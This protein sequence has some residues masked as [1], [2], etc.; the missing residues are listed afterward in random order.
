MSKP[1]VDEIEISLFGGQKQGESIV[2][3]LGNDNWAIIDSFNG[4]KSQTPI[5][6]DYLESIQVTPDQVKVII[7][8]H[9]HNDHVKGIVDIAMSCKNAEVWIPCV[10]DGASF[11]VLMKKLNRIKNTRF[12]PLLELNALLDADDDGLIE[13][14]RGKQDMV[15]YKDVVDNKQV[16]LVC[17]SPNDKTTRHFEKHIQ[18]V[19]DDKEESSMMVKSKDPNYQSLSV[20]LKIDG[21][22]VLLTGDLENLNQNIGLES[23][24]NSKLL[25]NNT[26]TVFKVPHHGS[27]NGYNEKVWKVFIDNE[28]TYLIM[29]PI[30]VG[31][32]ILP[33]NEMIKFFKKNY[34]KL[35]ITSDPYDGSGGL[36]HKPNTRRIIS[37]LNL[38]IEK[39]QD[40]FG[41]IRIR[42]ILGAKTKAT[43]DLYDKALML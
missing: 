17:L 22:H 25:P 24:L 34:E 33:N 7:L 8:T 15:L 35:Y 21:F 9:Y 41:Q 10:F 1:S 32:T 42:K 20:I 3:H 5:A 4:I 43:I 31:K 18:K 14:K 39:N 12:N 11:M 40:F 28:E 38:K 37:G 27:E 23:I 29:T 30:K 6:L 26:C 2:I 16:E 13:L 19:I 36:K